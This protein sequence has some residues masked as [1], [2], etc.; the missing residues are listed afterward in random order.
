MLGSAP[1][2][3]LALP[4]LVFPRA[5][6]PQG[7]EYLGNNHRGK[8]KTTKGS[9]FGWV[10][11]NIKKGRGKGPG[12]SHPKCSGGRHPGNPPPAAPTPSQTPSVTFSKPDEH[13]QV[14]NRCPHPL[15][16]PRGHYLHPLAARRHGKSSAETGD[17]PTSTAGRPPPRAPRA[18]QGRAGMGTLPKIHLFG[19][20]RVLAALRKG[21]ASP[22]VAPAGLKHAGEAAG[23]G[24]EL[25]PSPHEYCMS[26]EPE[27][28]AQAVPQPP[29]PLPG[30]SLLQH[31]PNLGTL[32]NR[33]SY[34]P[35][36]AW[37]GV[38]ERASPRIRHQSI[39]PA[40]HGVLPAD[41]LVPN[42]GLS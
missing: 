15:P 31:P 38:S 1:P 5:L 30:W 2:S 28:P 32:Q 21:R 39:H 25:T 34:W 7:D 42:K 6:Q 24:G 40:S 35:A 36:A 29:L 3:S 41:F 17:P 20:S 9:G 12:G 19:H 14:P 23:A 13:R 26:C 22:S 8:P 11:A 18:G 37:F 27:M 4:L 10:L 16:I 33:A